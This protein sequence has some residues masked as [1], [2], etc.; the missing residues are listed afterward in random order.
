MKRHKDKDKDNIPLL[1]IEQMEE[2][3]CK[4]KC[5]LGEYKIGFFCKWKFPDKFNILYALI[6]NSNLFSQDKSIKG[7]TIEFILNNKENKKY[8]KIIDDSKKIY[9]NNDYRISI[10]EIKLTDWLELKS[11]FK[12]SEDFLSQY[13]REANADLIYFQNNQKAKYTNGDLK[14]ISNNKTIFNHSCPN[15]KEVIGCLIISNKNNKVIGINLESNKGIIIEEI[16]N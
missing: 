16:L 8:K 2:K 1:I 15:E 14:Y 12:I 10:I 6:S 3:I 7:Q 4:I 13:E 11:F 5:K 9:I